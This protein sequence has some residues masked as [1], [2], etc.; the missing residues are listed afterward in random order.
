M[1]GSQLNKS[2]SAAIRLHHMSR[3][4]SYDEFA[5]EIGIGRTSLIK[6]EKGEANPTLETVETVAKN[7]GCDPFSL[8]GASALPD[9]GSA[10]LTMECLSSSPAQTL[11][12]LQQAHE[13]LMLAFHLLQSAQNSLAAAVSAQEK[14]TTSE[15]E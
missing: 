10:L 6:I 2:F 4:S 12:T 1:D 7:M 14:Q 8:L 13:H 5:R 9:I 15:K 3:K 11:D